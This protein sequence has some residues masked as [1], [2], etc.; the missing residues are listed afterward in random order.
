MCHDS[1]HGRDPDLDNKY[2]RDPDSD[3]ER[4]PICCG[5]ASRTF[6]GSGLR[7]HFAGERERERGRD[8][9]RERERARERERER[10]GD[11][12]RGSHE[13]KEKCKIS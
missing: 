5:E 9:E 10:A 4:F 13:P 12:A 6:H 8:G 11:R 3:G 1:D 7:F 2:N